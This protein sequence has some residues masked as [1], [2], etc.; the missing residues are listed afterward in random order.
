[1]ATVPALSIHGSNTPH[2]AIHSLGS[3]SPDEEKASLRLSDSSSSSEEDLL[4]KYH[5]PP[6]TGENKHRWDPK[7]TWTEDELRKLTRKL[8]WKVTLVAC[9]CFAALQLDRSN[10]SNALSD[11][12]L[13][14][15]KLTTNQYNYGQV[16]LS[17]RRRLET[18]IVTFRKMMAW[19]LVAISQVGLKNVHGFYATRALLGLLEG[20]V[21]STM[22]QE[23]F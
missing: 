4:A 12:M 19:S 6:D 14:D 15:L 13:K 10:I 1:M 3:D 7:A 22:F 17:A 21:E 18:H 8:D 2:Q 16:S 20:H 23:G 11:G 9:I 5:V